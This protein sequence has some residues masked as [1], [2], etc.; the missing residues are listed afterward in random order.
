MNTVIISRN[1]LINIKDANTD[2]LSEREEYQ[3]AEYVTQPLNQD[4]IIPN[5]PP[6]KLGSF[7]CTH[8]NQDNYAIITDNPIL[9]TLMVESGRITLDDNSWVNTADI[10]Q[11]HL[12]NYFK[13]TS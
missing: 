12:D 13:L 6:K 4:H 7:C 9:V 11:E 2:K 3:W 10:L 8:Y 1:L 5:L